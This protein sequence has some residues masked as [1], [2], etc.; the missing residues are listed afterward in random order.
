MNQHSYTYKILFIYFLLT[1]QKYFENMNIL[2]E[3]IGIKGK[4]NI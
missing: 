3:V 4:E 1:Y 2:V